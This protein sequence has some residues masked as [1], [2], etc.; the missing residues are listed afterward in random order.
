MVWPRKCIWL[1]GTWVTAESHEPLPQ[2]KVTKLMR[3][4]YDRFGM[5]FTAGDFTTDWHLLMTG[6]VVS[7]T[8]S[9]TWFIIVVKMILKSDELSE[10]I[11][12]LQSPKK[13]FLNDMTLISIDNHIAQ[14]ALLWSGQRCE[15]ERK[16][17][18]SDIS[19]A[20]ESIP[21]VKKEL[22]KCLGRVC[23]GTLSD[24]SHGMQIIKQG[25]IINDNSKLAGKYKSCCSLFGLYLRLSE[26]LLKREV[27]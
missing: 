26:P 23:A 17:A 27:A 5:R 22:V 15:L 7:C 25:W 16:D 6:I 19:A 21:T 9:F 3:I 14:N 4:Y 11:T 10:E 2:I 8:K 13:A 20:E 12:H 18:L 24:K 1:S